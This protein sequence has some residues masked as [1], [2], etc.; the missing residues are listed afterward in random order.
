MLPRMITSPF[1]GVL[2]IAISVSLCRAVRISQKPYVQSSRIF[3]CM[4]HVA[5]GRSSSDNSAVCYTLPVVSIT[6]CFYIIGHVVYGDAYRRFRAFAPA[7]CVA[8]RLAVWRQRRR[9]E[10]KL[11]S[12]GKRRHTPHAILRENMTLSTQPKVYNV[13]HCCLAFD[14]RG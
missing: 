6:S 2:S 7:V 5:V 12:G 1:R 14:Q 9:R 13:L 3:L 10:Q 8:S 4:I 11:W